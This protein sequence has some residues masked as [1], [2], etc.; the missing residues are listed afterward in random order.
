MAL[1]A[2]CYSPTCTSSLSPYQDKCYSAKCPDRERTLLNAIAPEERKTL[3]EF[4]E[5]QKSVID[6]L[7][8]LQTKVENLK[9]TVRSNVKDEELL[10]TY[11]DAHETPSLLIRDIVVKAPPTHPPLSV[12]LIKSLLQTRF[13]VKTSVHV[14]SEVKK[15]DPKLRTPFKQAPSVAGSE[16]RSNYDLGLTIIWKETRFN[17]PELVLNNKTPIIG[18]VNIARYFKRLLEA[19]KT[20]EDLSGATKSSLNDA[21]LDSIS[22]ILERRGSAEKEKAALLKSL[23]SRLS[24]QRWISSQNGLGVEDILAWRALHVGG[25]SLTMPK[26]VAEWAERCSSDPAFKEAIDLFQ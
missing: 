7:E 16:K 19:D 6:Q 20:S 25:K 13:K 12:I 15:L 5:H 11:Q 3:V 17:K 4:K 18:E 22:D 26:T 2:K 24:A 23:A 1:K 10:L 21:L 8:T 14:H 9:N